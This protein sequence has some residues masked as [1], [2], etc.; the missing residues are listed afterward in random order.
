MIINT[1]FRGSRVLFSVDIYY[2]YFIL[3]SK[4]AKLKLRTIF[5]LFSLTIATKSL[6]DIF[7]QVSTLAGVRNDDDVYAGWMPINKC[8]YL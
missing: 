6:I 4:R 3:T 2:F 1:T 8:Q 7:R 5:H